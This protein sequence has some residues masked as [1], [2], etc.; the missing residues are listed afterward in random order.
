MT[1]IDDPEIRRLDPRVIPLDR[2][3]G[4]I[5]SAAISAG[6]LIA[7]FILWLSGSF[8]TR[9]T[10]LLAGVWALVTAGSAWLSYQWP[11]LHYRF[12]S[13]KLDAKGIEIR[14]GVIWRTVIAV[15]RSRVQHIDVSQGP[16]ERSYGLGTLVIYTAGTAH[17]QVG[18]S[19]LAHR[20]ALSLRDHLL[21]TGEDDAV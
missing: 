3:V 5:V 2:A 12:T 4:W 13:Y 6:L 7:A 19:G 8:G 10:L 15:P 9:G 1:A 16:L 21:P 20:T 11:P 17:S 18:L 14:T